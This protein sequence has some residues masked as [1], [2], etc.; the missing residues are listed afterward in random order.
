VQDSLIGPVKPS[1]PIAFSRAASRFRSSS[2][3][4][5]SSPVTTFLPVTCWAVRIASAIS[6]EL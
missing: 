6:I 2:P 3:R 5:T 1:M 4:R